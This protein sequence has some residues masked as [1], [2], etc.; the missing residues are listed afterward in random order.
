M[1]K[2]VKSLCILLSVKQ[3]NNIFLKERSVTFNP[4]SGMVVT[5]YGVRSHK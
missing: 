3:K 2:K 1:Y 4:E 5:V